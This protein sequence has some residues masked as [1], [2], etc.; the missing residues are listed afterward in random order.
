MKL[1]GESAFTETAIENI[2]IPKH[3]EKICKRAFYNCKHLK[4]V[5]F[6]N[7]SE[8]TAI[9]E[10]AFSFTSIKDILI[11]LQFQ[12]ERE[13]FAYCEQLQEINFQC[14]SQLKFINE[15]AFSKA[16]L[17][18]IYPPNDFVSISENVFSD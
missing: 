12:I 5:D 18:K 3:A 9:G 1:I 14:N 10:N 2:T 13:A 6:S 8:L 15:K 7:N 11:Y 16:L 17:K 4:Q